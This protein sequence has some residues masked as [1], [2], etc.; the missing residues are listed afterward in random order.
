MNS[1]TTFISKENIATKLAEINATF[2]VNIL[3]TELLVN[4]YSVSSATDFLAARVEE[5]LNGEW[6]TAIILQKISDALN[7][8][9]NWHEDTSLHQI[10]PDKNN[11]RKHLKEIGNKIGYPIEKLLR[12]SKSLYGTCLVLLFLCIPAA[13]GLSWFFSSLLALLLIFTLYYLDR[14]GSAFRSKTLIEFAEEIEWK[15]NMEL[16][17]LGNRQNTEDIKSRLH[18]ILNP[19]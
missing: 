18:K 9:Q 6:S 5:E 17:K 7:D 4:D 3:P 1:S 12:P 10:F 13:I 15:R 8:Q 2:N 16:R 11:R 19:L 14:N